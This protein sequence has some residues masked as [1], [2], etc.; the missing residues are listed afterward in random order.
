MKWRTKLT[1]LCFLL[2]AVCL[3]SIGM[4]WKQYAEQDRDRHAFEDLAALVTTPE[5]S[6]QPDAT[7]GIPMP[8]LP[9]LPHP[10]K[11]DLPAVETEPPKRNLAPLIE[12]NSDC[13][14]WL[15]IPDTEIDYP[16]MHTPGEPQKYLRR[17]FEGEYSNSGIPFLDHRCSITGSNLILYG[18]NM[19]V[20][21]M[22][23]TLSRYLDESYRQAHSVI[24]FETPDGL[25]LFTVTQVI[26]TD[27]WDEWYDRIIPEDGA[28]YLILSTCYGASKSG[29]LLVIAAESSPVTPNN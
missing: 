26:R 24:E 5:E 23:G 10:I 14:G 16:V 6:T 8:S 3:F 21:T 17:N 2:S 25:R 4:A 15:C 28:V 13:V 18:H 19:K 11:P 27:I 22:F 7:Q 9:L 12:R 1:L 29:R 20:G